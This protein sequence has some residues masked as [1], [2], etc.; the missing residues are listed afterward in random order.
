M[1]KPSAHSKVCPLCTRALWGYAISGSGTI[2][3][4]SFVLARASTAWPPTFLK[5]PSAPVW[6]IARTTGHSPARS[7]LT[8]KSWLTPYPHSRQPG[9]SP[10]SSGFTPLLCVLGFSCCSVFWVYPAAPCF[11]VYPAALLS[12]PPRVAAG[13]P[14][15]SPFP[16]WPCCSVFPCLPRSSAFPG[17]SPCSVLS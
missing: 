9:K 2:T 7:S 17:L 5:T 8:G 10:C 4:T 11:L 3:T 12:A 16:G 1:L 14:R 15:C 6:S 13:L